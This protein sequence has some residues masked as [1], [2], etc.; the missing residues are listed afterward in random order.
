M[1]ERVLKNLK[2]MRNPEKVKTHYDT[3]LEEAISYIEQTNE[4]TSEMIDKNWLMKRALDDMFDA[5]INSII[6][7]KIC[8]YINEYC[9]E[10]N[11]KKSNI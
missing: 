10:Q 4:N 8:H 9:E 5:K 7:N 11:E 2:K 3:Y 1:K 6:F